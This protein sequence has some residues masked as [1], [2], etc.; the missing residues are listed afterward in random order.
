M[1]GKIVA[2]LIAAAP[3]AAA[4][5]GLVPPPLPAAAA[6][7]PPAAQSARPIGVQS[8]VVM[9][10]DAQLANAGCAQAWPNYEQSCLHD[11]RAADDRTR[12]VRVIALARSSPAQS[13]R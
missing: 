12:T 13:Q 1:I 5:V 10:H 11:N 3:C 9:R 6:E 8:T 4:I 2:A 7:T